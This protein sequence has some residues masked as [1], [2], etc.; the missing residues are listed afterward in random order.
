MVYQD[1][2]DYRSYIISDNSVSIAQFEPIIGEITD[3]REEQNEELSDKKEQIKAQLPFD[4]A[5]FAIAICLLNCLIL[6][7]TK[8]GKGGKRI[9][10]DV[11][12]CKSLM[13]W[14][15]YPMSF[16]VTYSIVNILVLKIIFVGL[17]SAGLIF[18]CIMLL[19]KDL[20][21]YTINGYFD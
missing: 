16:L 20:S 10:T 11:K 14:A 5:V 15:F 12:I 2:W 13:T 17:I 21:S 3:I 8:R 6:N 19:N 7:Y 1:I 18:F 9:I 4:F